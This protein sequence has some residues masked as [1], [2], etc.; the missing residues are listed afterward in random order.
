MSTQRDRSG[1]GFFRRLRLYLLVNCAPLWQLVQKIPPLHRFASRFIIRSAATATRRRPHPF[2]T[3]DDFSSWSSLTDKTYFARHLP[4]TDQTITEPRLEDVAALFIR[5]EGG[6]AECPK[7]TMLF[8]VFAQYLTDGFLRTNMEERDRTTSNHQIDL[9]P[10][11]G[12]LPRQTAVLRDSDGGGRLKSQTLN[13]EEYPLFLFLENGEVDPQ[14]CDD[15]GEPILDPPLGLTDIRHEAFERQ[16]FAMGGDRANAIPFVAAMNVLLLREHNRLADALAQKHPNWTDDQL[17]ET[18]RN[19]TIV[20][21]IKL[22]IEEYINHISSAQLPL[23]ADPTVTWRAPWNKPNWMTVEFALLYR[24]H[25]LV[26]DTVH[27]NGSEE[28]SPRFLRDNR[29]LVDRGLYGLFVDMA[30]TKVTKLTL[31]NTPEFLQPTETMAIEQARQLHVGLYNDYRDAFGLPRLDRFEQLT[32]DPEKCRALKA[33]YGTP[34]KLGFY[35]GLFAEDTN[36]N[37]PMP[38]LMGVMVAVDAFSQALTNPLLSEH[39]YNDKT[40]TSWGMAEIKGT[41]TVSD[42]VGRNSS[43][44]SGTTAA[45]AMTRPGWVRIKA[46]F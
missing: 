24:W 43:A 18:A 12:R 26:P 14:F 1:D 2:S 35:E 20:T 15:Q 32:G 34:D 21:F 11:Y 6:G 31:F 44:S 10:L 4:P 28:P 8:P 23:I 30:K 46:P 22:V 3:R 45:I 41:H 7:S 19:I 17:F 40:F 36:P 29:P 37:T 33:R 38:S 25:S 39:V 42:L 5:P 13:D 27:F 16:L 9:S